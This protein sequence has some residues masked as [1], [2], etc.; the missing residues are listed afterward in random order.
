MSVPAS[1][2]ATGPRVSRSTLRRLERASGRLAAASTVVMAERLPWFRRLTADQRAAV[3]L[4]TQTGA[5]NFVA[6]LSEPDET[7]R[8]T[9]EAFRSA[10]RELARRVTLRQ[11]VELVRVA[12]DVFEHQLPS[13]ASDADEERALIE[14][15]LRFGREIAFAAATVYASAAESRGAWDARL[16]ALVV[17]GVVRADADDALVSRSSALGWDPAAPLAVLVG[18]PPP[19]NPPELLSEIRRAASRAGRSALAGVQGPRLVVLLSGD[20]EPLP[21]TAAAATMAEA[22]GPGPVVV[23]PIADGLAGAHASARDA[24]AGLRAV[25]G[26][27]DAP[28]PVSAADLLPERVLSGDREAAPQLVQSVIAPLVG[29]GGELLSTLATYLEVG[30]VLEACARKQ[31]VHPNTVRYRLRRVAQLTGRA[32]TDP[33]DAVVLRFALMAGRLAGAD[34]PP[35]PR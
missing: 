22:F 11:T 33:R 31:F 2:P 32:P 18:A 12:I 19:D 14:A 9:A 25:A 20:A 35:Q 27:P 15:V 21:Q 4:V 29:A 5:A 1:T 24:M 13:L 8:L 10:P 28:R 16:E 3:L 17:D 34:D 30:G 7:I 6:W 23:G 26:W